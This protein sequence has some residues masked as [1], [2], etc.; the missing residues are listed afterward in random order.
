VFLF[1]NAITQAVRSDFEVMTDPTTRTGYWFKTIAV[2]ILPKLLM[3]AA[4]AGM[5]G[6]ALRRMLAASSEYDKTNYL[7]IPLSEDAKGNVTSIKIPQDDMGRLLGGILWKGLGLARGRTDTLS[8]LQQVADYTGG[9]LPN[10]SPI[11]NLVGSTAVYATGGNPRDTFRGRNV[12]SDQEQTARGWPAF[13]KFI[14]W[15]FQQVGGNLV[16]KWYNNEPFPK[17]KTWGQ[18]IIN[19]PLTGNV[20]GR[21]VTTG[22][23]GRAEEARAA[24][25]GAGQVEARRGLVE[26][27]AIYQLLKERQAQG[28][29]PPSSG[30]VNAL[31]LKVAKELYPTDRALQQDRQDNIKRRLQ[32][33]FKRGAADALADTVLNAPSTA[34][35]VA[36]LQEVRRQKGVA[37]FPTWLKHAREAGIVSDQTYQAYRKTLTPAR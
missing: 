26:R 31:A 37:A 35:K 1:S 13:K 12:L 15:E 4:A 9:Q 10:V 20:V 17:E 27:D 18:R 16:Y 19:L 22:Q 23:A 30:G 11:F 7:V 6:E 14:G 24:A 36:A 28:Q 32:M 8:T 25:R 5:M 2:N 21:F 3:A 29:R 34:Q 33:G